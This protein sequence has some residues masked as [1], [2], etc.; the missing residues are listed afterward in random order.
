MDATEKNKA[1]LFTVLGLVFHEHLGN[2]KEVEGVTEEV[3]RDP[4]LA[5]RTI[6]AAVMLIDQLMDSFPGGFFDAYETASRNIDNAHSSTHDIDHA[7][8]VGHGSRK[9]HRLFP[10]LH[11]AASGAHRYRS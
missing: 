1:T 7:R 5:A 2:S 4:D 10:H 6:H 11:D 8:E 3:V 9:R